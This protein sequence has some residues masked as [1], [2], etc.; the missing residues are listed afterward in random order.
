MDASGGKQQ[1]GEEEG[2]D[3]A[4]EEAEPGKIGQ[5]EGDE[6]PGTD[7]VYV[8]ASMVLPMRPIRLLLTALLCGGAVSREK[9]TELRKEG[10]KK[11]RRRTRTW[12]RRKTRKALPTS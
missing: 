10:R 8:L 4:M 12:C 11:R 1:Q 7:D 5:E 9:A 3:D 2:G 6:L